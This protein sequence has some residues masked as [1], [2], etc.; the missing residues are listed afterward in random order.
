M[1]DA[2]RGA[3]TPNSAAQMNLHRRNPRPIA[4]DSAFASALR[5]GRSHAVP[6]PLA[7]APIQR[8]SAVGFVP[9]NYRD[10]QRPRIIVARVDPIQ[11]VERTALGTRTS[12]RRTVP[13]S[14]QCTRPNGADDSL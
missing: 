13:T 6:S 3:L 8:A 14:V 1:H 9:L 12:I 5:Q 4:T 10:R 11:P 7:V 2:L